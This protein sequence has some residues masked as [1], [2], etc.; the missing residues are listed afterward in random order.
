[1]SG[2]GRENGMHAFESYTQIKNVYVDLRLTARRGWVG[3]ALPSSS[4]TFLIHTTTTFGK[5]LAAAGPRIPEQP[6]DS[7]V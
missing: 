2:M 6:A 3:A 5:A 1:M 4:R 7:A